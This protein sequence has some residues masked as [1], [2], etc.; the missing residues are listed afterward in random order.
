M[1]MTD[2][3]AKGYAAKAKNDTFKTFTQRCRRCGDRMD[4]K[5]LNANGVSDDEL[6]NERRE[7]FI[8]YE[9]NCGITKRLSGYSL[10]AA[11][12]RATYE[13]IKSEAK[14]AQK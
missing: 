3:F 7:G 6:A 10:T 4:C 8:K 5:A 2:L 14:E 9:P 11:G 1:K 12:V 13:K